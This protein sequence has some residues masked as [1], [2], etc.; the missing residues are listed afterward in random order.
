MKKLIF[1]AVAALTLGLASCSSDEV[2]PGNGGQPSFAQGGYAKVAIN[3]PSQ[4]GS[5]RGN[6]DDFEDGL[7]S[8]YKVNKATLIL[9][10][11][12]TETEA[13]FHSAYEL[14][15][16]MEDYE[17]SPNQITSTTK[18]VKRINNGD[19]TGKKLYAMVILNGGTNVSV[20]ADNLSATVYGKTLSSTGKEK[21]AALQA[22]NWTDANVNAA[23]FTDAGLLMSNAPLATKVSGS[24]GNEIKTLVD[25]SDAVYTTE[26]EAQASP[27]TDIYVERAVGKVTVKPKSGTLSKPTPAG[28]TTPDPTEVHFKGSTGAIPYQLVGWDLDLTNTESYFSRNV[29]GT[30][31]DLQS[32]ATGG[33]YR[34][35]GTKP[36]KTGVERYR[37]YFAKDPNYNWTATTFDASKFTKLAKNHTFNTKFGDDAPQYC[38]ENTFN[39]DNQNQNQTTRVILKVKIGDGSD[40]YTFN[41]DNTTLY[42]YN[43][44]L[45]RIKQTILH[46]MEGKAGFSSL[47]E[48]GIT[49]VTVSAYDA[50]TGIVKVTGFKA[51]KT[52]TPAGGGAPT[53]STETFDA[54]SAEVSEVNTDLK[55]ITM[56]KDGIAYY[57]VR[58]KHFG[59]DLTPWNK[60]E[61]TAPTPGTIYPTAN[62]EKNYLGRYGVVRNNW[63]EIAVNSIKGIGSSIIPDPTDEPDD[64]LYNYIAV[65]INVLSWAKRTQNEDL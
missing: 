57:P 65:R 30:W 25:F 26:A 1:P 56:Y 19:L 31:N 12:G 46:V 42:K 55:T 45:N 36:V 4:S 48:A 6:N 29:D 64:E 13:E 3:L 28:S 59:D 16:S 53:V 47:N 54:S 41:G 52:T 23:T 7:A 61:T 18:I 10:Q 21:I 8:E 60:T 11:G 44:A 34:F 9:F 17:D 37:T 43:D 51:Q 33:A 39:V 2:N 62:A 15:V 5:S 40:F 22:L 27:A 63:Y 32:N 35:I 14:K 20:G 24:T 58:I 38:L 50:A 49:G